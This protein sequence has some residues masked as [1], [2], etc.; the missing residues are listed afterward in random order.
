M[1]PPASARGKSE[2]KATKGHELELKLENIGCLRLDL[3]IQR[4]FDIELNISLFSSKDQLPFVLEAE[5]LSLHFPGWKKKIRLPIEQK[6]QFSQDLFW[7][8]ILG[9]VGHKILSWNVRL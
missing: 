2:L 1:F 4:H 5:R 6:P 8:F 7:F 3:K 9:L